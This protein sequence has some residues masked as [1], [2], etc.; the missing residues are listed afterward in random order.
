MDALLRQLW[1]HKQ[2]LAERQREAS[3]EL[4]LHFLQSSRCGGGA[5]GGG[6]GCVSMCGCI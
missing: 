4:L 1:E 3:L 5:G 2:E 6:G